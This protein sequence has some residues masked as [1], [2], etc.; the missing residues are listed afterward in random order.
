MR[1]VAAA[2][3][4]ARRLARKRA[5]HR[6]QRAPTALSFFPGYRESVGVAHITAAFDSWCA[7]QRVPRASL[8]ADDAT[9]NNFVSFLLDAADDPAD[10]GIGNGGDLGVGEAWDDGF[11]DVEDD[12]EGDVDD[13]APP[14]ATPPPPPP[15]PSVVPTAVV[16]KHATRLAAV[17]GRQGRLTP[18]GAL[19]AGRRAAKQREAAAREQEE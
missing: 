17:R 6:A 5:A 18:G 3:S 15:S 12:G 14:A 9:V 7:T 13:D 19:T 2:A 16:H 8:A 4:T 11:V 1:V 10:D